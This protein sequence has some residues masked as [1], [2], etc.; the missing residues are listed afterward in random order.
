MREIKRIYIIDDDPIFVFGIKRFLEMAQLGEE[1]VHYANGKQAL[2]GLIALGGSSSDWPDLIMV[3]LNM[4]VLDGWQFLE[5]YSELQHQKKPLVFIVSS[6]IDPVDLRRAKEF[7]FVNEF[8]VKPI[9]AQQ[10][11]EIVE[12]YK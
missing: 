7:H 8:V 1:F 9:G 3:D 5:A 6:S 2:D 12:K 11:K 10:L 4:P